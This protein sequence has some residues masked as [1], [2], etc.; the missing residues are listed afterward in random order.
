MAEDQARKG[1]PQDIDP[2]GE[3]QNFWRGYFEQTA[4]QS[5]MILETMVGGKSSAELRARWL[6]ALGQSFDT[7]MRT[8]AFL[9]LLRSSL[10]RMIEL[11]R[12]RNPSDAGVGGLMSHGQ[13]PRPG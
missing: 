1:G 2:A 12:L 7:F 9:E 10:Q 6:E 5:Q 4:I 11:K 8:P 3:F 13:A